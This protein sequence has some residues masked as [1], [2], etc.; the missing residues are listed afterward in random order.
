MMTGNVFPL[1]GVTDP[2]TD[3]IRITHWNKPGIGLVTMAPTGTGDFIPVGGEPDTVL[4]I[5]PN[6]DF[7]FDPGSAK[8][9]RYGDQT[10]SVTVSYTDDKAPDHTD[11]P[12]P[13]RENQVIPFHFVGDLSAN[14][15]PGAMS[16]EIE[17]TP[18]A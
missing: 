2:D 11:D 14:Q 3:N 8:T 15:A 17:Y 13:D 5:M 6:G 12:T 16:G 9:A 7:T 18:D 4:N 1:L 10:L